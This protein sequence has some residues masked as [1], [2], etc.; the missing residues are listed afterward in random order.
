MASIQVGDSA[1]DFT[2]QSHAGQQV[3]LADYR[4]KSA[5]V[6]FFYPKDESPIC[7][8]EACSFRDAYED[9]IKAGAVVIGVSSDSV[10]SHQ[11]FAAGH[12]LP[13]VLLADSDGSLRK[14]FGVPKTLGV[15]PG[16]VTYVIDKEGVVRHVFN[17]QFSAERHVSEAL[18]MLRQLVSS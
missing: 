8:K 18:N 11:A 5:V 1:P 15:M 17:S 10:E 12:R 16:R 3:S 14:A 6:L 7:T 13:F 2:A 9:F 4:G